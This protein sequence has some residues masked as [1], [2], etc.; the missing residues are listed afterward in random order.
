MGEANL[1]LPLGLRA[2]RYMYDLLVFPYLNEAMVSHP[3]LSVCC[4]LGRRA[5]PLA[6]YSTRSPHAMCS[7]TRDVSILSHGERWVA[8][9]SFSHSVVARQ[10]YTRARSTPLPPEQSLPSLFVAKRGKDPE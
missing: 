9:L 4:A 1:G 6:V 10:L 2:S 8:D 7:P 5:P 3:Y